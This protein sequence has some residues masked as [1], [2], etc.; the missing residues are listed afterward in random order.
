MTITGVAMEYSTLTAVRIGGL[1]HENGNMMLLDALAD[2]LVSEIKGHGH[3]GNVMH[4]VAT[5][6]WAAVDRALQELLLL[7]QDHKGL[8]PLARNLVTMLHGSVTANLRA[9]RPWLLRRIERQTT[10]LYCRSLARRLDALA[11]RIR[12]DPP[13]F[14][15]SAARILHEAR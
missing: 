5:G 10:D 6:D 13:A 9:F 7:P 14:T 12:S 11:A 2:V 15:K 1:L 8:S 4:H 3:Y